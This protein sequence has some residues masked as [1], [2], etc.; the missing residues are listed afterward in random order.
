MFE[1]VDMPRGNG[2]SRI[3]SRS[4]VHGNFV[5]RTAGLPDTSDAQT[6]V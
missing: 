3:A 2:R 1:L 6:A 4:T 5:R